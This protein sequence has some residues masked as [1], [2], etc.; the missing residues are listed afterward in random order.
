MRIST[1][2][3]APLLLFSLAA[4]AGQ[5]PT[6]ALATPLSEGSTPIPDHEKSGQETTYAFGAGWAQLPRWMGASRQKNFAVPY[7]NINWRDRVEFSTNNGL[8]ADLIHAGPWHGGLVGTM[9]WGRSYNDLGSL[10]NR[11]PTLN[12]TLQAG[13]YLEY[14]LTKEFNVG[15]RLRHDIQGTGAAYGDIY[16]NLDLPSPGLIEHSLRIASEAM[17]RAAMRRYFGI[18]PATAAALGTSPYEPKGGYSQLSLSYDAFVPTS[19]STGVAL[20]AGYSRLS[21][22][23]A[24]SPLVRDFGS[25]NQRS[26]MAAF[27]YHF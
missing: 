12:N 13:A 24:D 18:S 2:L 27:V 4:G 19:Q 15:V 26:F 11:I 7:I 6:V 3:A 9:M 1:K 16:A 20:S 21:G 5:E 23:A 14:A 10:S 25:P 8:I 22:R 17:N